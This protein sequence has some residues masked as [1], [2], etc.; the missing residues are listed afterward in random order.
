MNPRQAALFLDRDGI[1][2]EMVYDPTHGLV[3]SPRRPEQVRAVAGAGAFLREARARGFFLSVVT[4]QP[5]VAKGTLTLAD[6]DAVHARLA[7]LLAREGGQWDELR[8]CPHHPVAAPG[9]DPAYVRRCDCRKPAPGLLLAALREH[10]LDAGSSWMIGDGL[11]DV[12]AGRAAGCR[13]ILVTRLKIEQIE[14]FV[15]LGAEPDHVV[16]DLRAAL[17]RLPLRA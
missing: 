5:G 4:N 14:R 10:G 13:T 9:A 8:F 15:E 7:E 6:L 17:D 1:L 3:D 11:N 12:Q 16:P 2:N